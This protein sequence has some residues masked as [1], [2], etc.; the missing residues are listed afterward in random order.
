[1]D[2]L[3]KAKQVASG[4][5]HSCAI[6]ASDGTVYCWGD[7]TYGQLG[8]GTADTQPHPK[9]SKVGGISKAIR[10]AGGDKTSFAL[11]EDGT[12]WGWGFGIRKPVKLPLTDVVQISAG[13]KHNCAIRKNGTVACWGFN[14]FGQLGEGTADDSAAPVEIKGISNATSIAAGE[15]HTCAVLSE[16][17]VVCWGGNEAGQLGI[18]Q[19]DRN[20]HE[21]PTAIEDKR[22]RQ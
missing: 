10:I 12:V 5:N 7:D 4:T 20:R 11:L 6:A 14:D 1:V 21:H 8:R 22:C 3:P 15:Q 9:A 13:G 18:G 16:G 2:G 17:G 19:A